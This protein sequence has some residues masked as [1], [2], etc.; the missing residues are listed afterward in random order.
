MKKVYKKS[1]ITFFICYICITAILD[2]KI[3]VNKRFIKDYPNKEQ[4][5]RLT[6]LST[7]NFYEPYI[8]LYN[9][10]NYYYKQER[11]EEAYKKYKEALKHKIP[12][13]RQCSVDI[14]I[15]LSIIEFAKQ[16]SKEEELELYK[17][18][19]EYLKDC[20]SLDFSSK[21]EVEKQEDEKDNNEEKIKNVE[22]IMRNID[23]RINDIDNTGIDYKEE[24]AGTISFSSGKGSP[25]GSGDSDSS[26]G[27]GGSGGSDSSESD[28]SGE[29]ISSGKSSSN[30]GGGGGSS[31][32]SGNSGSSGN[33]GNSNSGEGNIDSSE[34]PDPL[35]GN[36]TGSK[37][38]SSKSAR[39]PFNCDK[40]W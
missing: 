15:S 27:S 11:Y 25:S 13:E 31:S 3:I 20:L 40:C 12:I 5:A 21:S 17:E 22:E 2:L 26:G 39:K 10:G 6:F 8:A 30:G 38:D 19:K 35:F 14:N 4:S 37:E 32:G 33:S 34:G 24:I 16:K 36:K 29:G 18:A 9:Y 28:G 7:L 1:I 23:N